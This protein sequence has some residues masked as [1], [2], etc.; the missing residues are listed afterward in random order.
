MASQF[1][2][3][4]G[5]VLDLR[6]VDPDDGLPWDFSKPLKVVKAKALVDEVTPIPISDPRAGWYRYWLHEH[7]AWRSNW[8]DECWKDLMSDPTTKVVQEV[9]GE[10]KY[11]TN[12]P[13]IARSLGRRCPDTDPWVKDLIKGRTKQ[14]YPLGLVKAM[15]VELRRDQMAHDGYIDIGNL[16]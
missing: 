1:G 7:P 11:V 8:G 3:N 9:K 13:Y 5:F 2:L 6:A 12:S 14:I 10:M 4:P 16:D 15:L